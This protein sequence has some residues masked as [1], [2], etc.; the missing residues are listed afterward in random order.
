MGSARLRHDAAFAAAHALLDM[1]CGM[2]MNSEKR[3][4]HDEAYHIVLAAL[5]AYSIQAE[6]EEMRV[7]PS[8]N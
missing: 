1:A 6:R 3:A 5:E 8:R 7:K 2:L 4:F